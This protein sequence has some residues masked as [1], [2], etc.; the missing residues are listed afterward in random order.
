MLYKIMANTELVNTEPLFL[1]KII[2]IDIDTYIDIDS[3]FI[4]M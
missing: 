3:I 2:D 1:W 4:Y